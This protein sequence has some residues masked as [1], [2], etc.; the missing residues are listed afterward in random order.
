MISEP[1]LFTDQL[2]LFI[3]SRLDFPQNRATLATHENPYHRRSRATWTRLR[4]LRLKRLFA[5]HPYAGAPAKSRGGLH[6]S[7][8]CQRLCLFH[9]GAPG[10]WRLTSPGWALRSAGSDDSRRNHRQH[11]DLS[12]SDGAGRLSACARLY[13]PRAIPG[14]AVPTSFYSAAQ[15]VGSHKP[16]YKPDEVAEVVA[17]SVLAN[18]HA[19]RVLS[20]A[21]RRRLSLAK[22]EQHFG[23][24]PKWARGG[25]CVPQSS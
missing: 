9:W 11:P 17:I 15:A 23:A 1:C 3:I 21:P 10:D 5:F 18:R 22:Q 24:A 7:V 2:S 16:V 14:V 12:R 6:A 25:A 20:S 4:R 8:P 19:A 13:R